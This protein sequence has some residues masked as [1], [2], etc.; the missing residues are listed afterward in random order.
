[1]INVLF[2][3]MPIFKYKRDPNDSCIQAVSKRYTQWL[4]QI[5]IVL[6]TY[7]ARNISLPPTLYH[8]RE[9]MRMFEC[10]RVPHIYVQICIGGINFIRRTLCPN[11]WDE[12]GYCNS[13]HYF[14]ICPT[15]LNFEQWI[16]VSRRAGEDASHSR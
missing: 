10:V 6:L 11:M 4:L 1:M 2:F 8:L 9:L 15:I 7:I 12:T 13:C 5:D 16:L 3:A 14:E